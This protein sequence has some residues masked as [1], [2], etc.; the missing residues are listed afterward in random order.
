MG[1]ARNGAT[2]DALFDAVVKMVMA[3]QNWLTIASALDYVKDH[4]TY[5][6][7]R[8]LNGKEDRAYNKYTKLRRDIEATFGIPFIEISNIVNAN[9]AENYFM[10]QRV[11]LDVQDYIID[12]AS[13]LKDF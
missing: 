4:G 12:H 8:S 11:W 2:M 9:G 3:Y 5:K 13:E 6:Q 10:V 7:V 1:V